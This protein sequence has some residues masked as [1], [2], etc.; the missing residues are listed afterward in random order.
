MKTLFKF[1]LWIVIICVLIFAG[2]TA[3]HKIERYIY[4]IEYS[5]IVESQAKE[6]NLDLSLIY[7]VIKCESGFDETAVSSA[8]ARGLMQ[9]QK[10]TY[11]WVCSR[12]KDTD[13]DED[14]LFD[15]QKN[16]QAG[17]RLLRLH[18]NEFGDLKTAI[19]AY[20]A[21]RNKV[22]EWLSNEKYSSDG[23]TLEIIPYA[24]TSSYVDKVVKTIENY[25]KIYE[26]N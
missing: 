13:V 20:H 16:I 11:E 7:A 17:C 12:Y 21:G 1:V 15:P 14:Y 4:P 22:L 9:L 18:L 2:T 5:E 3:Y 26:L 23:K 6:Y 25:K 10:E 8:D 24:D 19:C